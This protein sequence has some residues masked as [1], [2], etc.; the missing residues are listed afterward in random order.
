MDRD[1]DN[2]FSVQQPGKAIGRDV[3]NREFLRRQDLPRAG[4]FNRLDLVGRRDLYEQRGVVDNHLALAAVDQVARPSELVIARRAEGVLYQ[5]HRF[6]N[7]ALLVQVLDVVELAVVGI[8]KAIGKKILA[9]NAQQN[10]NPEA[11]R[12]RAQVATRKYSRPEVRDV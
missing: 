5:Q 3:G 12:L 9:G 8:P 7:L 11:S 10:E 6:R 2:R 1:R 4:R